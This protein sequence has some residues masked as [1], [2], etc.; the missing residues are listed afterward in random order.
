MAV[1][2]LCPGRLAAGLVDTLPF[3]ASTGLLGMIF[4]AGAQAAGIGQA[5]AVLMSVVVFSG[6]GQ[7]AA[8]PLWSQ[9]AGIIVLSTFVLSLRFALMTASMAPRLAN[10]PPW[11]RAA[12]AYGVTDENYA[13]AVSRRGGE[14]EPDY[15]AGSWAVLYLSWVLGTA[16]GVFFG[17]Q[18]PAQ[19][20]ASL[21]AVFPIVFVTL[22]V[23]CCTSVP[24]AV[25]AALGALLGA[26]GALYLPA[27][28]GVVIA[29]LLASLAGPLL[30][31]RKPRGRRP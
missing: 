18:V 10:A 28:W 20:V 24:T 2:G 30:E 29:G 19:L 16:A 21:N 27:G 6:S 23:L 1:T 26:L 12:V 11:L 5:T 15:L 7:F 31:R 9:G 8:L 25:V 3:V 14:M 17:A 13:L 22:V 4:G